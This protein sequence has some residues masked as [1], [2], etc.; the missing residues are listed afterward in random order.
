MIPLPLTVLSLA[1]LAGGLASAAAMA[2]RVIRHPPHMKVMVLVWPLCA[3]FAGPLVLWFHARYGHGH[4]SE[5]TPFAAVVAK[6]TLHCG[7][8][9][10]LGDILAETLA[11]LVPAVLVPFGYPGLF[12]NRIFA[13]WGLDFVFAFALGLAFQYFAIAPM[14]GLGLKDGL[15]AA[16]K[17]DAASLAAW[18]IGMYGAMAV[19]HFAVFPRIAPGAEVTAA[20]P[21][22]WFAMQI[23]MIAG[24]CTAYPVNAWLIRA[25]IKERM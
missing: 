10:T 8:G 2:R 25:G 17:A 12:G 11:L 21:L 24:F 14:R 4:A 15:R 7:A 9:C 19:A 6:G 18:Q 20:D 1:A 5:D 13:V 3:L 22:F 16:L 23:A